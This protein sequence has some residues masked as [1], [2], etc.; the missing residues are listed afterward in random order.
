MKKQVK[1]R[2][3]PRV[4]RQLTAGKQRQATRHQGICNT[5]SCR[6]IAEELQKYINPEIDPCQGMHSNVPFQP[7][8]ITLASMT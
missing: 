1:K 4:P 2:K 3:T 5:E 6:K 8:L 7:V